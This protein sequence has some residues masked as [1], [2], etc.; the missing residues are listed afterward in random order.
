[1]LLLCALIVGSSSV[2]AE[3]ITTTCTFSSKAWAADNGGTW[4][5]GK[6]GYSL[7]SGRGIQVTKGVTGANGT[8]GDSFENV[9]KIVVTYSTNASSGAGS[10]AVKVGTGTAK[11]QDV[12]ST[13]GTTDR[14][15]TYDFAQ[16]ETGQVNIAVTCTTNSIYIKSVAITTI[17]GKKETF[18]Y[19]DN[20]G[21]GTIDSGSSYTMWGIDVS[22]TNDMFY[23]SN[24]YSYFYGYAALGTG[25]TTITPHNGATIERIEITTVDTDH[26]GWQIIG[27]EDPGEITASVGTITANNADK[28]KAT[29]TTWTGSATEQFTITNTRTIAWSSIKVY[30]T[31]GLPK[32]ATPVISGET[33]FLTNT[34]VSISCETAGATIQ[35]CTTTDGVNY[36]AYQTYTGPFQI[37]ES[38]TVKA[39]ATKEH[40]VPSDEA[41][42]AFSQQ[43]VI[44]NI[45]YF[46]SS[47]ATVAF[48]DPEY[49][50]IEDALVTYKNGN[51]AYIQDSYSA[52]MLS[53]CADEVEAGDKINGYMKVTG[54]NTSNN[55]PKITAFELVEGYV[56]TPEPEVNPTVVTLAEL[57]GGGASSPYE[58]YLSKYVK[59]ENATVTSAFASKNCTIQQGDYSI[60]LRDQNSTATLTSTV[61]DN[62]T[63]TGIVTIYNT[64]QQIA[65]YEQGQIVVSAAPPTIVATPSSLTGFSYGVDNGPSAT[66]TITVS[67]AHLT[68]DITLTMGNDKYEMSLTEASGYANSLTIT[69]SSG[70]IA[71]TTVYVRLKAGLDMNPS[72]SGSITIASTDATSKT[73]TLA[74]S[75]E[76]HNITWDLSKASYDASPTEELIQWSSAVAIMKN[77]RNGSGNTAV[78]NYIPTTN[79]STRFYKNN[80][81]TVTPATGYAVKKVVFE[82]TTAGYASALAGSTWTNAGVKVDGTT[83]TVTPKDP[84][85]AWSVVFGGTCGFTSVKVYYEAAAAI[86][87]I[88]LNYSSANFPVAGGDGTIDV[89]YN[90]IT[91]VNADIVWYTDETATITTTEPEWISAEINSSKN[92][93]YVVGEN[94]GA[95]RTAYLKVHAK[96]DSSN[97]VYS[98]LIT[99]T[100]A[101]YVDPASVASVTLDFTDAAWGFP[102]EYVKTEASYTNGYKV[103]L[104]ASS[105]GHKK[106]TSGTSTTGIIFGKQ[107]ATLTLPEF[108]FNVSKIKVYGISG[109]SAKVTYNV[110]VG[111]DAVS[112]EV[113]SAAVDHEFDIA[114]DKQDA[115]TIYTIK[116]TNDNNCQISKIEV[117][118]YVPVTVGTSGYTTFWTKSAN[119]KALRFDGVKAYVVPS[120]SGITVTLAEITEAPS[121][122]PVIIEATAGVHNLAVIPSA[123]VVEPNLLQTSRGTS[124]GGESTDSDYYVLSEKGGKVGFYKLGNGVAV[125]DG[126]CFLSIPKSTS[127]A[128]F[129][130]FGG[131]ATGINSVDSG[132]VTVDSS[133]V[134]NLAG[135]RVAQPTKGLY[136]VN[137]RKVVIK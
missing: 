69:Q 10:I 109:A 66:Q 62:V 76:E 61:G 110:F 18:S 113:T 39:Q 5:S 79:T 80:K 73:I 68:D 114:A 27:T 67:G 19:V 72:Y 64:T 52:I 71:A 70:S 108:D 3:E 29:V 131:E 58:M 137:G 53:N 25:T 105:N 74:G 12:T 119:G 133:E 43:G 38:K 44:P 104:G 56:K 28:T 36:T 134:Y 122:T 121:W 99:I 41:Y 6:D 35:Y 34:T 129:L 8:S 107:D 95:A 65:V 88:T 59:I 98:P 24:L 100:Q 120:V 50:R 118:G 37:T 97:D 30:L 75:V 2:W 55:M 111:T 91:T 94:D 92:L 89:T 46:I 130:G 11:S 117:F 17:S 45:G 84:L 42:K 112:T 54:Y 63:V 127:A 128:D 106:L 83:V 125:P 90:N 20:Q 9:S 103:T 124:V 26:N 32:C 7:T 23:G 16:C 48:S 126:K 93:Y 132:Q 4:T 31:G 22:I 13:G 96:D 15:L 87:S 102:T 77:E 21:K 85:T 14:T 116:L 57:L 78:N 123:A 33:P 81:L 40:M 82:A 115:G 135:Q 47:H 51:T 86:P 101:E 1:M 60:I 136:I 49:V